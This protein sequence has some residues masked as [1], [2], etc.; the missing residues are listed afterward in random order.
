MH[1]QNFSTVR[2]TLSCAMTHIDLRM[3][4]DSL[5][6]LD[7]LVQNCNSAPLAKDS[8]KI[9]P[10]FLSMYVVGYISKSTNVKW[11]IKVLI[12]LANVYLLDQDDYSVKRMKRWFKGTWKLCTSTRSIMPPFANLDE[13]MISIDNCEKETLSIEFIDA[14]NEVCPDEKVESYTEITIL[15]ETAA[16]LENIVIKNVW[17]KICQIHVWFTSLFNYNKQFPKSVRNYCI[18]I[19]KYYM[20]SPSRKWVSRCSLSRKWVSRCSLSRK[21]VSRYSPSRKWVSR[22]SPSKK[23]VF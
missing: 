18:S 21:W 22:C 19:L 17:N 10:N 15:S 9:L 1:F 3:K 7:V 11:R 20:C 23:W 5:L 4:E 14:M 12:C 8:H 13:D 2:Q 6:F 16:L